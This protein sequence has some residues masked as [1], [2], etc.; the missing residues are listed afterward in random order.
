MIGDQL[1][2]SSHQGLLVAL[3]IAYQ[4]VFVPVLDLIIAPWRTGAVKE[5]E[6]DAR[7]RLLK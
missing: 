3:T 6:N 5:L 1:F 2:L 4:H 7:L